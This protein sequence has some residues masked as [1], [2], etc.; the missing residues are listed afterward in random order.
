MK[1]PS[2]SEARLL[3]QEAQKLENA[4]KSARLLARPD[5]QV[6]RRSVDP[7]DIFH[8][9]IT[10][11]METPDRA[12]TWSRSGAAR[13]WTEDQ[14]EP[15]VAKLAQFTQLTWAELDGHTT[16]TGHKMH[17]LMDVDAICD[18][19]QDRLIEIDRLDGDTIFRFRLG[20]K[21]RLWGFRQGVNFDVIWLDREHDVYPTDPS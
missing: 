21:P 16:D 7:A 6:A 14:W 12:G 19:A 4:E 13:D 8:S 20:N 2:R 11:S 10:W 1:R 9:Q 18:E 17:H 15:V 5:L 3:R